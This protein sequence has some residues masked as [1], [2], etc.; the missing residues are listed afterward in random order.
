MLQYDLTNTPFFHALS[1]SQLPSDAEMFAITVGLL[2][3]RD[4]AYSDLLEC[5]LIVSPVD[6]ESIALCLET[7]LH[8]LVRDFDGRQSLRHELQN[9]I[10]LRIALVGK[11]H[12]ATT[13]ALR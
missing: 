12:R 9:F 10:G 1:S 6:V 11:P 5:D 2:M 7:Q 3:V 8:P 13:G 4:A